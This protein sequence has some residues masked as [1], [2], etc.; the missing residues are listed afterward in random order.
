MPIEVNAEGA[1]GK[2]LVPVVKVVKRPEAH[3]VFDMV[4]QTVLEGDFLEAY[5]QGDNARILPTETQKN[6]C[7]AIAMKCEFDSVEEYALQLGRHFISSLK[8]IHRATV[9]VDANQ[10]TRFQVQGKPHQHVFTGPADPSKHTCQAVVC[11]QQGET[12]T[13]GVRDLQLMKTTQSGFAGFIVDQYTDIKPV[14]PSVAASPDRILCTNATI[15]W[16]YATR[17]LRLEGAAEDKEYKRKNEEILTLMLEKFAGPAETGVYSKSVQETV[18]QMG[19]DAMQVHPDV[20]AVFFRLPNVHHY[21]YNLD[22]FGMKNPNVVF[23]KAGIPNNASG[24]IE[25]RLTRKVSK[26]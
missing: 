23:Q 16:T 25:L 3:T 5:T 11:R 14:D 15:N 4:V 7:Y 9:T 17:P 19:V 20:D 6:T 18:Y 12:V 26:L 2:Q 8:H 1:Y 21:V 22:K 10:W 13:S 24:L